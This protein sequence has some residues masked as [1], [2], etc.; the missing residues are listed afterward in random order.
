MRKW[1]VAAGILLSLHAAAQVNR[2]ELEA[3]QGGAVQFENY[4]GT[5]AVIDS[6][7]AIVGIGTAL[8]NEVAAGLEN[9]LSVQPYAKYSVY[10][11]VGSE[12]EGGL[13]ADILFINAS[14]GVDHINNLRRIIT[15]YLMAAYGYGREDA[16][17]LSVFITVYNAVYRGNL[18][19]FSSKYKGAVLTYLTEEAVGL[20]TNWEDWAGGTQIVIPLGELSAEGGAVE[21]SVI[22]D[23]KVIEALR[24]EDDKNVEVRESLASIKENEAAS[25]SEKAKAAQKEAA[26]AKKD[27]DKAA[28]DENAKTAEEQQKLA[29]KKGDEAHS[30]REQIAKDKAS[31]ERT[32]REKAAVAAENQKYLTS[33]FVADEKSRLYSL[34]TVNPESGEVVRRSNLRQIREKTLCPVSNAVVQNEDGTDTALKEAFIA[35]CGVTDGKAAVRLCIIDA[36]SL[37]IRKQSEETLAENSPLLQ[38]DGSFYVIVADGGKNYL[39]SYD[40]NLS[41]KKRSDVAISGA[42]PL[43]LFSEGIL[44]TDEGGNPVLLSVPALAS[45]WGAR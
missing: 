34:M 39:A 4:G 38:S 43:N 2:G 30:E 26:Q 27:G 24:A 13:D 21:T 18:A 22:S 19:N 29:D 31:V 35:V 40:K 23:D 44:V 8:G 36:E 20:S 33:L 11:V 6:A 25:A 16:E 41:L 10:H 3:G 28:A 9:P 15:G 42:S 17:T 7:A 37:E 32:G 12:G 14:A 45:V 1:F 5:H